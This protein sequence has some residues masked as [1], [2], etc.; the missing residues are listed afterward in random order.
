MLVAYMLALLAFHGERRSEVFQTLVGS[1]QAQLKHHLWTISAR[2]RDF[3][4][5]SKGVVHGS[6]LEPLDL[7][8]G[9]DR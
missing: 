5:M 8:M 7:A 6:K 4:L 1:G 2:E 3:W 9:L